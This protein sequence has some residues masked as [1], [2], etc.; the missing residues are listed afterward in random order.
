MNTLAY[1][2][3]RKA[4]PL[5]FK[6]NWIMKSLAGSESEKIAAELQM[7]MLLAQAYEEQIPSAENNRLAKITDPLVACLRNK[8]ALTQ[9]E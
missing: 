2:L 3:G 1:M 8:E 9:P 7:G 6:A 5:F 4:A